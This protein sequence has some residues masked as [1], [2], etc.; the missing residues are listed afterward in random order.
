MS[1]TD[2]VIQTTVDSSNPLDDPLHDPED[3][4]AANLGDGEAQKNAASLS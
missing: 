3:A 1:I 2:T 4:W